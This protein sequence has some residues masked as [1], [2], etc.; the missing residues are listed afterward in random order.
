MRLRLAGW[1]CS[2]VFWAEAAAAA[3]PPPLAGKGDD[4]LP[5]LFDC[6]REEDAVI[7]SAHRGGPAPGFP[8]NA[9]ATFENTL[10]Q[11]PAVL[12]IDIMRSADGELV[13]MHDDTL[14]RTTTGEGPVSA[15]TLA[16]LRRLHL[17]DN[18]GVTTKHRIPTLDM[19]LKWGEGRAV[20]ALDRKDPIS[21]EDIIAAVERR[22]AFGR[23]MF[24]TYS[25]DDAIRVAKA[26]PLAVIVT[27]LESEGDLETLRQ[28]GVSLDRIIAW[29]GT[30]TP[31]PD[32]YRALAEAGVE[33]VFAT[34]GG[35]TGSWD[36]RILVL[37]DDT[38]Y[39]RITEGV[40]LVATDRPG[41]VVAALPRA[42]RATA[43]LGERP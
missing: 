32:L 22:G 42:A 28:A 6:L 38:L 33:S 24:A 3:N 2:A 30:E 16:A 35:W 25:L 13:L 39:R 41:D 40:Q 37:G 21:Y 31:R 43:C 19:A 9:I 17:V 34:L 10:S 4:A 11:V 20:F 5:V 29:T 26:A 1:M 23:V 15:Q 18:E 27:P 36:N 14:D 12:E 7:V 8:E